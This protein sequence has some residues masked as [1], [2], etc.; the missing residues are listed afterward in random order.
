MAPGFM[1]RCHEC[2]R[3]DVRLGWFVVA[4]LII[5]A[6]LVVVA[7]GSNLLEY[8]KTETSQ[9]NEVYHEARTRGYCLLRTGRNLLLKIFPV[10]AVKILVVV[11][12]IITQVYIYIYI[13]LSCI[14]CQVVY[15]SIMLMMFLR[16]QK[17]DTTPLIYI[18]CQRMVWIVYCQ[19]TA[20]AKICIRVT[21]LVDSLGMS[22][23]CSIANRAVSCDVC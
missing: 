4:I 16:V 12:E 8:V 14:F 2:S 18:S 10:S 20:T 23:V 19:C 15:V 9:V 21:Y 11:L 1:W 13:Y 5:V 7:V 3:A 6:T 17:T 22:R